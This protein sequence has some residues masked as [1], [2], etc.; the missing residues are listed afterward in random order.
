MDRRQFASQMLVP[1]LGVTPWMAQ[2]AGNKAKPAAPAPA[3][4]A[5][6]HFRALTSTQVTQAPA[7]KV[8][9]VEI[10]GYYC[11]HCDHID[12]IVSQ[13]RAAQGADIFFRRVPF[14]PA[15]ATDILQKMYF[16]LEVDG[17]IDR[18]HAAIFNAFHREKVRFQ[19]AE[20]AADWV[21]KQG[22]DRARFLSLLNS[23]T[24]QMKSRTAKQ[25]A[26]G[27][28]IEGVPA[29]GVAGLYV[30]NLNA[31]VS[32]NTIL[33]VVDALVKRQRKA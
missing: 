30:V 3:L 19:T 16:A 33:D 12:P 17:H 25:L 8:E 24:V 22:V 7:G 29:F 11:P 20:V 10:F 18:L 21:A 14:S 13:W 32:Q 15:P 26:D 23:F 4:E 1:A 27:Y 2:A 9:V 6:V 28:G 31:A 5:G